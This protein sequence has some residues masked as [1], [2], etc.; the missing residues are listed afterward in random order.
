MSLSYATN[1]DERYSGP[2]MMGQMLTP[3]IEMTEQYIIATLAS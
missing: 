3:S 2:A 1:R